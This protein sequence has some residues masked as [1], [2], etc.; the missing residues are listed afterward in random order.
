MGET[1]NMDTDGVKDGEELRGVEGSKP[2][3]EYIV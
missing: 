1:E 2:S 3:S